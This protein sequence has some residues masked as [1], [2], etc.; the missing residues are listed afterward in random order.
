MTF[1]ELQNALRIL[2]LGERANL[3]EI[4]SRHRTLV[5]CHHPDAGNTDNPEIIREVNAAYRVLMDYVTEYRLC[6][7]EDEFYEQNPEEH[8]RRQF[9][10][11]PK[12]GKR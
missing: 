11:D 12:W 3:K 5:K 9:M 10:D 4:K 2:G 1:V 7:A 6:F 8:L